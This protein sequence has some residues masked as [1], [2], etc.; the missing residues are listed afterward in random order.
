MAAAAAPEAWGTTAATAAPYTTSDHDGTRYDMGIW[1]ALQSLR[2]V[3]DV[4]KY[5]ILAQKCDS[6]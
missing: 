3:S 2:G 1:G 5:A 6:K 4:H